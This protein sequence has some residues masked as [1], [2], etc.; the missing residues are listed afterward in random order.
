[1]PHI[2]DFNRNYISPLLYKLLKESSTQILLLGH[3]NIDQ[4]KYESC[5]LV[6]CFLAILS[7]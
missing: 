2:G 5:K 7:T 6:N 4:L 1:M 3:F